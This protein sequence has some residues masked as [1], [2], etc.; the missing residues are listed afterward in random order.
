[1]IEDIYH[2]LWHWQTEKYVGQNENTFWD[3]WAW[4][5]QRV[6]VLLCVKILY[7][8]QFKFQ[9]S[10]PFFTILTQAWPLRL[11]TPNYCLKQVQN[12]ITIQP[13]HENFH[14]KK[15]RWKIWTFLVDQMFIHSWKHWV[16]SSWLAYKY[17]LSHT[18]KRICILHNCITGSAGAAVPCIQ[19][20]PR[21]S[22]RQSTGGG[23]DT[24]N[25]EKVEECW[26]NWFLCILFI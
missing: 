20:L 23:G 24:T 18:H 10:V 14:F 22:S 6:I 4:T 16:F 5:A 25:L 15:Q 8:K 11:P 2:S 9:L 13:R 3:L 1:M 7:R 12:K 21:G 19:E 17:T 26:M